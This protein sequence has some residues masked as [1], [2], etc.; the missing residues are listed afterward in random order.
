MASA[1]RSPTSRCWRSPATCCRGMARRRPTP[2][3][4][5]P[6]ATRNAGSVS[7]SPILEAE[8]HDTFRNELA[9]VGVDGRRRWIYARQPA[10]RWYRARTAVSV[11]LLAFLFSAPFVTVGGQP[12]VMLNVLERKFVLLGV[13]FPPQDL[14]LVV[15][16]ALAALVTLLLVTVIAGRIWCGWLCPQTVFMEMVFRRLEY[17]IDGSAEQQL[18]RNR[19]PWT[20]DRVWRAIVKQSLFAGLSLVIANVFLA[21]I[22]GAAAVGALIAET[23]LRHPAGF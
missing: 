6:N 17:A 21:W 2:S 10:G 1:S 19:G 9:S 18:R 14:Y 23:P 11:V 12:L 22:V 15:V 4:W 3:R 16:I 7:A 20:P 5:N 13:V 8:Q